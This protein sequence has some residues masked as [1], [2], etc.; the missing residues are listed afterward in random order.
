MKQLL[1]L[2]GKGGTGKTTITGAFIKLSSCKSYADCDVDA[3]NLHL[4][5]KQNSIAEAQD[6]YGMNKY[7]IDELKCLGCGIC[8]TLCKFDAI[9]KNGKTYQIDP[10]S[11]EGCAVCEY[12]CPIGIISPKQ[13]VSGELLLYRSEA[14]FSTA[15]IKA[16]GGNSGLLV[17]EVKKRLRQDNIV[18]FEIIDGSPGI[19]CPVIASMSGADLIL[20]VTEPSL[21]GISDMN[22][23]AITAKKFHV[24]TIVCIN[25]TTPMSKNVNIILAYCAENSIPMVG[26]IPYDETVNSSINQGLSIVDTDCQAGN[27]VRK[28]YDKVRQFINLT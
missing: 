6:F 27:A 8:K 28:V 1:I 25:K 7:E 14:L 24:P 18:D 17:T 16:G 13:H 15:K 5:M 10:F 23:I 21:S 22:R 19:G 9:H 11:C 26:T 4:I 3:P 2:S 12:F 20:L